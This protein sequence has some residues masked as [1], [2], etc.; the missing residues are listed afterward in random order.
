MQRF[1]WVCLLVCPLFFSGCLATIA[2]KRPDHIHLL[3][4]YQPLKTLLGQVYAKTLSQN[5]K[6]S[7][8]F[9]LQDGDKA[10]LQRIALIRLATRNIDIQTYIYK[11]DISSRVMMSELYKAAN[12]GVKVRLLIDDNGL[13]SDMSDIIMLNT[14]PN[15]DVKI[16]NP[17]HVRNKGLRYLEMMACYDRIKKRMH[18]K[19]F[20]VD[21]VALVIGG[22]NIAD[23][24]FDN[25]LDENFLD[26]DA[27]FLGAVSLKAKQSFLEYWN[28]KGAIP[29]NLLPSHRKLKKYAKTYAKSLSKLLLG[30]Q[31]TYDKEVQAFIQKFINKQNK[32]YL[33]RAYFIADRPE[34]IY[35]L[36]PTSPINHALQEILKHT[37]NSLYIASSYLIPGPAL[38]KTFQQK[39]SEGLELS[40]LTNSLASTDAIVVY[41]A[42]ERYA[43]KLV[44][45]G[46]NVYETKSELSHYIKYTRKGGVRFKIKGRLKNSLHSKILIFDSQLTWIGSF[47]LDARSAQINTE[48]VVVFDNPGFALYL[49]RRMQEQMRG[50]WHLILEKHALHSKLIWEG[51]EDGQVVRHN[52][53]PD[54]SP[55]LRFIKNWSKILPE[56]E[57]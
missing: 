26:T 46:A 35:A 32:G 21:N 11:N 15:I 22:R 13:D 29:A 20:I 19:I 4:S 57:L 52:T 24:Y 44:K 48:S 45:A 34:K 51:V 33:G 42:W 28:F 23:V 6:E 27:L 2:K 31:S 39:L 55:F 54:T 9:I 30:E 8:G 7:L 10:L 17:Y 40:I 41:G 49:Q 37:T 38:L 14:H 56:D 50:S 18:N 12:R 36:N 25:D 3:E 16:F 47:N 1:L 5:P 53:P 43:K